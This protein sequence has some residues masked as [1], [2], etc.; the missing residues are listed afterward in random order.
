MSVRRTVFPGGSRQGDHMTTGRARTGSLPGLMA[1]LLVVVL[2]V[3]PGAEQVPRGLQERADRGDPQAQTE[4]GSRYYAGRGAPQDDAEAVR[5]TRLAAEQ[6][7]APAQYNLGLLYFRS[8][9]VLGDD[10]E[11]AR[12]YRAAAEQGYAPGQGGLGYMYAYGAGVERDPVRAYMWL[13]LARTGADSD[14]TREL[15]ARQRDE[16]ASEMTAEQVGEAQGLA[17]EWTPAPER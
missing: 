9:G 5:W 11:A 12:W 4:L 8:R 7:H 15:Y 16:L 3:S 10:A 1:A 2:A 13:E 17:R 14:F 6:G